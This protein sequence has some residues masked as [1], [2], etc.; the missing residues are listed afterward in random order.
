MKPALGD[1]VIVVGV[2]ANG[3]TEHPGL[4]SRIWPSQMLE[5]GEVQHVNLHCF[6][7][8]HP[9]L[10]M[11][12]VAYYPSLAQANERKAK[13]PFCFPKPSKEV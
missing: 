3:A 8:G 2:H 1:S 13:V 10:P 11:T 4:L 7:D 9:S 12:S 6:R 5:N